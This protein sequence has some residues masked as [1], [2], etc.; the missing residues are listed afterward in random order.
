M[1]WEENRAIR[2]GSGRRTKKGQPVRREEGQA[3]ES[4]CMSREPSV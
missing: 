1:N 3:K 4:S 2:R